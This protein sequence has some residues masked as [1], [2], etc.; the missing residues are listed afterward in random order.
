M[1][2]TKELIIN[3]LKYYDMNQEKYGKLFNKCKYYSYIKNNSD[4]DHNKILFYDEKQEKIFESRYE[5]IGKYY[6]SSHIWVWSWAH[7][8]MRKNMIYITKKIL[9]Y[10]IDI[11]PSEDTNF[12]KAELV[13][14]RFKIYSDIQLDIHA[15]IASYISKQPMIF[16]Q[17]FSPE[18]K[19]DTEE[20]IHPLETE[21]RKFDTISYLYLLDKPS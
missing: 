4:L 16:K 6:Y 10:G 14:S 18:T 21:P 19:T 5:I 13:T 11:A 3:A 2:Q 12:I 8:N 7:P 1:S 20:M 15:A 17:I 9:N